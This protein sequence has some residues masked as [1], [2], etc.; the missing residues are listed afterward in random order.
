MK[1][2][3]HPILANMAVSWKSSLIGLL[4][5]LSV[6]GPEI[7]IWVRGHQGANQTMF[8]IGFF[9]FVGGLIVRDGDKSSEQTGAGVVDPPKLA[10]IHDVPRPLV[11]LALALILSGLTACAPA[12]P[13]RRNGEMTM[14]QAYEQAHQ[15][16][17][18]LFDGYEKAAIISHTKRMDVELKVN[19]TNFAAQVKL[20]P[21]KWASASDISA[22]QVR[23]QAEHD[24]RIAAYAA[25]LQSYRAIKQKNETVNIVT[26]RALRDAL[27]PPKPPTA[28]V[29][30][31][32]QISTAVATPAS[33][34][35]V[36][37]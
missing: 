3:V 17:S 10:P 9:A 11:I 16:D 2:E 5:F 34:S 18:D 37:P 4:A 33:G 28:T 6:S 7:L 13:T 8:W 12:S 23:L 14:A 32:G 31:S 29:N 30:L 27:N 24:Q 21:I 22:E 20:D 1:L 19:Q 36:Q 15:N 35:I 25:S 26:A